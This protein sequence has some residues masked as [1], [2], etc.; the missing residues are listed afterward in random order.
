MKYPAGAFAL[1]F[2]VTTIHAAVFHVDRN[3]NSTTPNGSSWA[4]AFP[5]IQQGVLAAQAAGGGEV[6]V[7]DGIYTGSMGNPADSDGV[8]AGDTTLIL[9]TGVHVY[10]GFASGETTREARDWNAH[11]TI[12]DGQDLRRGVYSTG[13]LNGEATLDGF[14]VRRGRAAEFGGGLYNDQSAP[15]IANCRF[16]NNYAGLKGGGAFNYRAPRQESLGYK[17]L[18]RSLAIRL[19][20][21]YH[22]A[23]ENVAFTGNSAGYAGGG[24]Y[25][26]SELTTV[27]RCTFVNNASGVGGGVYDKGGFTEFFRCVF[28]GNRATDA[29]AGYCYE[30][31]ATTEFTN[32]QLDHNDAAVVGGGIYSDGYHVS[33]MYSTVAKNSA[34]QGG[35]VYGARAYTLALD[36]IAYGNGA[37][38]IDDIASDPLSLLGSCVEYAAADP[39][40][41]VINTNPLFLAPNLGIFGL[42]AVSPALDAGISGWAKVSD[43]LNGAPRPQGPE[44]DMGALEDH[45]QPASMDIDGDGID[46]FWEMLYFGSLLAD[47]T[48]D[49]DGDG[50]SEY[51]EF[52]H[53]TLPNDPDTDHD[54]ILDG[55]EVGAGTDP[56]NAASVPSDVYVDGDSGSDDSGLGTRAAPWATVA[57][58]VDSVTGTPDNTV[59]I[60]VAKGVYTKL[61]AAGGALVPDSYEHL[62]GGYEAVGWTRDVTA[63]ET[64]LDASVAVNGTPAPNVIILDRVAEV[65]LDGLTITGA[66]A[67]EQ[68]ADDSAGILGTE[69]D[70][71]TVI[72]NCQIV[73][74]R[75]SIAGSGGIRLFYSSPVIT[76]SLIAS[77]FAYGSGGGIL[78]SGAPSHLAMDRC[79]ISGNRGFGGGLV[80]G[81]GATVTITNCVLSAN[82]AGSWAGGGILYGGEAGSV[83]ANTTIAHNDANW[84]SGGGV[85]VLAGIPLF[86]NCIFAGNRDFAILDD[87]PT[88]GLNLLNCLFNGNPEGDYHRNTINRNGAAAINTLT[89]ASGNIDG[90]PGFLTSQGTWTQAHTYSQATRRT[91]LVDGQASFTPGALAGT[92]VALSSPT[93]GLLPVYSNSATTIEVAGRVS[94]SISVG[95][96]YYLIDY[97][98]Q[99]GSAAIDMGIDTSAP[100]DGG[101]LV[102]FDGVAR[103]FDGD[104]DGAATADGSDYDIGAYES[105][106]PMAP[107][108]TVLAPNGGEVITRGSLQTIT[109]TSFGEVGANVKIIARKGSSTGVVANS[110]PND[111]THEWLVPM[112]FPTGNNLVLEISSV[113]TPTVLDNS[114]GPFTVQAGTAIAGTVTVLSP[115]G[116]ESLLRGAVTPITWSSTGNIGGAVKIVLRRGTGST[117]ISGMTANDGQFD[118]TVPTSSPVASGYTIEISASLAAGIVDSSNASFSLTDTP[119]PVGT[120]TV[121]APNGDETYLQGATVPITWSSTGSPGANVDILARRGAASF[122]VVSSTPNDGAFNWIVPTDQA[123][124]ADY[125]IEVRST[126]TPAITDTSNAP[127]TIEVPPSLTLNAPNGGE[128]YLQG[129]TVPITWS[130]AGN[131]GANVEIVARRGATTQ[132]IAASTPNDGAFDWTIP[133]NQTP[134]TDYTI[135]V[136]SLT[137]A[138]LADGSNAAFTIQAPVPADG[139]TVLTPNGGE[140]LVRGTTAQIRWS[141]TGSVGSTVKITIRRGTYTGTLFGSTP[142]DGVQAWNIPASYATGADFSI[143]IT[144]LANPAITDSSNAGFTIS[145]SAPVAGITVTA[146]NGGESFTQGGTLP[147]TWTSTGDIGANV[148]ILALGAGQTFTL[149]AS[150]ANDGAFDWAISTGQPA[151]TNYTIQIRSL[152]TPTISDTS[153]AAFAINAMALTDAITVVA[154][155]GGEVL[156]RGTTTQIRWDST[157]TPGTSVKIVIRSGSYTGTLFGSTPND[158]VQNWNIPATYA[159]GSTFKI[160]ISSVA[161]PAI[162]DASNGNFSIVAP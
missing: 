8:A 21:V 10:G 109:W 105:D 49:S 154:P 120:L 65:L 85:N 9:P 75:G 18:S 149:A 31:T 1:M 68:G 33:L 44:V 6:W 72:N 134:G 35:G 160:E 20:L 86:I 60:H 56:L 39:A 67:P 128:V 38:N 69:L 90:D 82:N 45:T 27:E 34:P 161:N 153:N 116:G 98:L 77:N 40:Q 118:W 24:L 104:G 158:G 159:T 119:P 114:D 42:A 88:T 131:T 7:A 4:S 29:G 15:V 126:T 83:I 148:E 136:R 55:T 17:N 150:T 11:P 106:T 140:T 66:N 25:L 102:D 141:S 91:T 147:V 152:A 127:F 26:D 74:N 95:S 121:A 139:I 144:S 78:V 137:V 3:A 132:A 96:T 43:D 47:G 117:I 155:N 89:G 87:S 61:N 112:S 101:V 16:E 5:T 53:G 110:T 93:Q 156:T 14:I 48:G 36:S 133:T 19:G 2:C 30:G 129:A 145:A 162:G 103:G 115:N 107:T 51:D 92:F 97:H 80:V 71:T 22:P 157:G 23:F 41:G 111:G 99:P 28:Q 37:S 58:A 146:P 76:N 122:T 100:E 52:V 138:G 130:S 54:G 84:N 62:L 73:R 59:S 94:S 125:V 151:A 57:Y 63:H 79:T 81:D 12:I 143:E 50:L 32:C 70:A 46:D 124:G 113:A 13:V 64:I 123:P 142:N 135:E 108:I